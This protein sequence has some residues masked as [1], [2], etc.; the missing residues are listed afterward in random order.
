MKFALTTLAFTG[1]M[2]A[3]A[4]ATKAPAPAA[5]KAAPATKSAAPA[6]KSAA[7][8]A[9]AAPKAA[10]P[11]LLQPSSLKARAPE[12]F[13]AKLATTKGDVIIEVTRAWAPMA[14]DRFYNLIRGG[15]FTDTAFFRVVPGFVVQFG[16]SPRPDVSRAWRD[17]N[18]LDEPVKESN[19]KG[20]LTFARAGANSRST[21]LFINLANNPALDNMGGIGF[22]PFGRVV[23]G[24]EHVEQIFSGYGE[25]P[26]QF[27][28]QSQG[29]AYLDRNFP[30]LDKIVTATIMPADGAPTVDNAKKAAT[31]AAD[32]KK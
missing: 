21:Q 27:Q 13:K 24:M 11:S 5:K 3:Q 28:I 32:A 30:K 18:I 29:K 4:P 1:L 12:V 19:K 22:P 15:F 20:Y 25:Q 26:D 10:A 7:P 2:F 6:A 23:E 9:K 31:P 8:A 16:L 17:A 14:A